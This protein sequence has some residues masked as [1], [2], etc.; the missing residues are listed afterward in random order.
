MGNLPHM[1]HRISSLIFLFIVIAFVFAVLGWL[2]RLLRP[3]SA[4]PYV[5]VEKLFSPA[6][7]SFLGVLEQI[8][9]NDQRIFG[10]VRLFDIIEPERGLSVK[11]YSAARNRIWNKHVDFVLCNAHTLDVIGVIELDDS[12]HK[13]E[14]QRRGDELKDKALGAAGVP[15]V[16]IPAQR[17]YTPA[18]IRERIAPLFASNG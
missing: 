5:R 8:C 2:V 4:F 18:E 16:R 14:S 13:R 11:A 7:R 15:M 6:E 17:G 12:S 3:R 9:G 1:D 10:K